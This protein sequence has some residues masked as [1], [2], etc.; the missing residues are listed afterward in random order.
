MV[1]HERSSLGAQGVAS[2]ACAINKQKHTLVSPVM[3]EMHGIPGG[4]DPELVKAVSNAVAS[5]I[6]RSLSKQE[7]F[8][9]T[10]KVARSALLSVLWERTNQRPLVIV[11]ILE[12]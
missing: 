12:L 2:I 7:S 3:V 5:A 9:E 1:L 10:K 4:D 6:K 11:N 8:N